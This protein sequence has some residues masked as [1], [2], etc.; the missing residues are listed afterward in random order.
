MYE[1]A[2]N[3]V[4][5]LCSFD[6]LGYDGQPSAMSG[7]NGGSDTVGKQNVQLTRVRIYWCRC[8]S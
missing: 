6:A 8:F 3:Q 2:V 4:H 5:A 1:C 7:V